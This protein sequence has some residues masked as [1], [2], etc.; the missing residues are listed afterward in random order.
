MSCAHE[1][2]RILDSRVPLNDL[3]DLHMLY[4]ERVDCTV[5]R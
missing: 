4:D 2:G 3:V 1:L 5:Y